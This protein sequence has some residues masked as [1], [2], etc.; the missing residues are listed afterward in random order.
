MEPSGEEYHQSVPLSPWA[1]FRH[2]YPKIL[3]FKDRDRL[4]KQENCMAFWL[5]ISVSGADFD[6][7][8][9]LLKQKM[10][11]SEKDGTVKGGSS[12]G[13]LGFSMRHGEEEWVLW[14][15]SATSEGSRPESSASAP[16]GKG[17]TR[18]HGERF[19]NGIWQGGGESCLEELPEGPWLLSHRDT[20]HSEAI[21]GWAGKQWHPK[22]HT[23]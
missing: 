3:A 7:F 16:A 12:W 9:H 20:R 19:L 18:G 21:S 6:L 5:W 1:H 11:K 8:L 13:C 10:R 15:T 14:P 2:R 17:E 4:N 22:M 23:S